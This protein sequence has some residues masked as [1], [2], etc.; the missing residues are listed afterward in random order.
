MKNT[1]TSGILAWGLLAG[2]VGVQAQD[3]P[4]TGFHQP[5]A[6]QQNPF[7][8]GNRLPLQ[9]SPFIRLPIGAITPQGWLRR[10]LELDASGMCGNL[11]KVS[12]FIK[13]RCAWASPTGEGHNGWE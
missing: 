5:D 7:Y 2:A 1:L 10:Q 3:N 4:Q 13:D 8:P 11:A 12:N 9:P 6:S